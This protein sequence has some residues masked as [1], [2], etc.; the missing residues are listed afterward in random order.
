M[1]AGRTVSFSAIT[2]AVA[3]AGLFMIKAPMIQMIAVG[4]VIVTLFAVFTAAT[5]VPA[6][7]VLL[8]SRLLKP[9]P[10]EKIPGFAFLFQHLGDA[11]TKRGVFSKLA[12][13]VHA[14]PWRV[15]IVITV[16][17]VCVTLPVKGLQLRS[18]FIE[19][20][21]ENSPVSQAMEKVN[22]EYPAFQTPDILIYAETQADEVQ[23]LITDIKKHDEI[24]DVFTSADKND[25][26]MI[27]IFTNAKD[28]VGKEVTR[29]VEDLRTQEPGYPIHVGGAAAMQLDFSHALYT[30]APMRLQ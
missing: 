22:S 17:L 25:G 15:L 29:L 26:T 10:L 19:Y 13:W 7:I 9:S 1:T 12:S 14:R 23:D 18:N 16:L 27:S 3:I 11:S 6:L 30:G 24:T 4:G 5:F 28:S 21:P 20:V 8:G 2:I